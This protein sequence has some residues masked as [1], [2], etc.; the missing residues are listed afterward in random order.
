MKRAAPTWESSAKKEA[1]QLY[2]YNSFTR[3]KVWLKFLFKNSASKSLS[4]AQN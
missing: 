1:D 3:Q 2:L 4:S